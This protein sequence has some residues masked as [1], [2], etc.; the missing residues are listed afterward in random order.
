MASGLRVAEIE[1]TLFVC[2]DS[3]KT[4]NA[5]GVE[6]AE[7]LRQQLKGIEKKHTALVWGVAPGSRI[8]C[9]GGNLKSYA[10]DKT[11]KAGIAA[12]RKIRSALMALEQLPIPTVAILSGD[13]FGGGLELLSCFDYILA[14]P[15]VL[16]GFWQRRIGLSYGWGGGSRWLRRLTPAQLKLLTLEA[17]HFSVYEAHAIGM[18]DVIL[19]E[20]RLLDEAKQWAE[21]VQSSPMVN[22]TTIKRFEPKNEARE[23]EK[24]WFNKEHR[25]VLQAYSR[26]QAK[27]RK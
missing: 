8:F 5:L 22:F 6:E 13:C 9:S 23:F 27:P 7:A 11:A 21:R 16:L 3:P 15:H 25:R 20:H 4:G 1:S 17:R 26:A 14:A 24:L 10:K 18:V 2:I 12:N 19:P